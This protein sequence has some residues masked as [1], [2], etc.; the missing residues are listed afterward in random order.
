MKSMASHARSYMPRRGDGVAEVVNAI[1]RQIFSRIRFSALGLAAGSL[2]PLGRR[3]LEGQQAGGAGVGN[4][5]GGMIGWRSGA[6]HDR[7]LMNM[8]MVDCSR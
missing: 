4:T 5:P 6:G 3:G 8:A 1:E 7:W 2:S